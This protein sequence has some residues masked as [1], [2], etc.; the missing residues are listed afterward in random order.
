[1]GIVNIDKV[2][3][4]NVLSDVFLADQLGW[5]RMGIADINTV[6]LLNELSCVFF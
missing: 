5:Q 2:V 4:L 6:C 3:L 1:M